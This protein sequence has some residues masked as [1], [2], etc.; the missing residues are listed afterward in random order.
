M[1]TPPPTKVPRQHTATRTQEPM[2]PRP[3]SSLSQEPSVSARTPTE[4]TR[5]LPTPPIPGPR[6]TELPRPGQEQFARTQAIPK[7]PDPE[8]PSTPSTQTTQQHTPA[9]TP[10]T[11]PTRPVAAN[12]NDN[13]HP[14]YRDV[15][16]DGSSPVGQELPSTSSAVRNQEVRTSQLQSQRP[17]I[18]SKADELE[19]WKKQVEEKQKALDEVSPFDNH[20]TPNYLFRL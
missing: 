1:P 9:P 13:P 14:E 12:G 5:P 15:P 3:R 17:L 10:A 4:P 6:L 18:P 16:M 20:L 19:F 7:P 2:S 8:P 11:E